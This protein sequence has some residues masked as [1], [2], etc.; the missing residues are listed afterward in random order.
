MGRR[1]LQIDSTSQLA[2]QALVGLAEAFGGK[3]GEVGY[4]GARETARSAGFPP[5]LVAGPA[6]AVAG[7]W[8]EAEHLRADL[9]RPG[10]DPSTE[11]DVAFAYLVFGHR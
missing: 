9:R 10:T 7:R 4:A 11:V 5:R 3:P 8:S 2:F 1:G 6:H